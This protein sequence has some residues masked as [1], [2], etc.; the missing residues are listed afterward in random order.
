MSANQQQQK[1][2]FN[3][4]HWGWRQEEEGQKEKNYYRMGGD[5]NIKRFVNL[6]YMNTLRL[7]AKAYIIYNNTVLQTLVATNTKG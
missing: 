3:F 2:V 5:V 7:V 4:Y 6:V 1:Q